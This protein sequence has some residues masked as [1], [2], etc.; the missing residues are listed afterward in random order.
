M[1]EVVPFWSTNPEAWIFGEAKCKIV[2]E[3][4]DAVPRIPDKCEFEAAE[5]HFFADYVAQGTRPGMLQ[6][7][8]SVRRVL[9]QGRRS[10]E[11][12]AAAGR[13]ERFGNASPRA[14]RDMDKYEF[15][16]R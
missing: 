6:P 13:S 10:P 12:E 1:C 9:R 15:V 16:R 4:H 11:G 7:K 14:F 8:A 5:P 2:E 3:R